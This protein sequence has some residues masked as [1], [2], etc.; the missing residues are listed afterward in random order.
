MRSR[1][2]GS[3]RL[4]MR[5]IEQLH[6]GV[7][8]LVLALCSIGIFMQYSAAGG[9]FYPWAYAQIVRLL[10]ALVLCLIIAFIPLQTLYRSAYLIYA[11]CLILLIVVDIAGHIGM[12][13]Q[14]WI[15]V[16]GVNLQPSELMKLATIMALARY[17]HNFFPNEK[18]NIVH[19]LIPLALIGLPCLLILRQP[20][21]GT[22]TILA[23]TSAIIF[24]V[25]GVRW[26][27]FISVSGAALAALPIAWQFLHDYQ[28]RRVLTFIN[29]EE[30]PLGAGYNIIQSMI[31][32]GSG[33]MFGKGFLKGSQAQ[34]DFLPEKQTDFVFTMLAEEFGFAGSIILLLCF[35]LLLIYCLGIG[36]R[37][38]SRFGALIAAG[39]AGMIFL[40]VFINIGMSMGMLPVVGVP[41]PL[42][43]YGGTML[44]ASLIGVGLLMNVWVHRDVKF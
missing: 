27:Y 34:L 3:S 44:I 28:K 25:A 11:L 10:P 33:G 7:L 1:Y 19:L 22:A 39:F 29:P 42:L 2:L 8:I 23:V 16:G 43:S 9:H 6:W 12:G 20:N 15:A 30:D 35:A 41:L 31:A 21:L 24:F 13:A 14:R 38:R 37:S 17:F 32:V 18:P 4:I 26:I 5:Y 36:M 40:H